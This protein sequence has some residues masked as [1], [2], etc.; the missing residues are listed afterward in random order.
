MKMMFSR[1]LLGVLI[2]VPVAGS[3][4]ADLDT[5]INTTPTLGSEIKRGI[6][7]ELACQ[8]RAMAANDF[9]L[10]TFAIEEKNRQKVVDYNAF[11]VGLFFNAWL[12]M[13]IFANPSGP[14]DN[15]LAKSVA[16]ASH[17]EAAKMLTV[18]RSLRKKVGVTDEQVIAISGMSKN[19]LEAR[20]AVWASQPEP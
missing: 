1:V 7:A 16:A 8:S 2:M 20:L 19:L 11:D 3:C 14:P 4:A 15:D 13:D 17:S 10:C 9:A 5:P 6:D 12:T 18:Y